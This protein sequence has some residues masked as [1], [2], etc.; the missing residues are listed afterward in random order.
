MRGVKFYALA[1][2]K[3]KSNEF[4]KKKF[5]VYSYSMKVKKISKSKGE[6]HAVLQIRLGEDLEAYGEHRC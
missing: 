3:R 2:E 4:V 5:T 6:I 1:R